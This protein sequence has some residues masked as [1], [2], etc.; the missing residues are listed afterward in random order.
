[1]W[2]YAFVGEAVPWPFSEVDRLLALLEELP[3]SR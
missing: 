1:M 3:N 2:L